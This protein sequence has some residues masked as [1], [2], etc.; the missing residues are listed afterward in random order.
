M[1][2]YWLHSF[3]KTDTHLE[4][5][6]ALFWS[7]CVN[8]LCLL[9]SQTYHVEELQICMADTAQETSIS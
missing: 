3:Y 6:V 7:V 1:L 2:C 4:G 5:I 9:Q 8:M